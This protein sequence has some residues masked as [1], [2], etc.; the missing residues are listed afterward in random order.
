M[1]NAAS[2]TDAGARAGAPASATSPRSNSPNAGAAASAGNAGAAANTGA[3]GQSG[4]AITPQLDAGTGNP[5]DRLVAPST[6]RGDALTDAYAVLTRG[7]RTSVA[8]VVAAI[9][10][11]MVANPD[12]KYAVFYAGA[13]RLWQLAETLNITAAP[14]VLDNLQRAHA[15][16]PD[17]FRV[18]GFYGVSQVLVGTLS[19]PQGV[20]AGLQTLALGVQQ[21]PTYNHFLRATALSF[22]SASDPA[23][24]TALSDMQGF[25]PDCDLTIDS[26]GTYHYPMNP[27]AGRTRVCTNDGI[28]PH[29]WEGYFITFGDIALKSGWDAKRARAIYRSAQ[30]A[31]TYQAWPFKQELEQRIIDA[32]MNAAAYADGN[33]LNDPTVWALSGSICVGCH[34]EK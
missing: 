24:P 13:F 28:V 19:D 8:S 4:A 14:G 3:A 32:D 6:M 11:Q 1:K 27:V 7:D 18:T 16:L 34:Q 31:P 17:D 20:D 12:D 23:F 5:D 21:H 9:D 22:L 26:D 15:L 29:L 25:G 30:T 33:P 2:S 10:A